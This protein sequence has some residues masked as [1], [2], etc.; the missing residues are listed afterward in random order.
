MNSAA[1]ACPQCQSS[2]PS[3]LCNTGAPVQCP[4]CDTT[5]QVEIFPAHFARMRTGPAAEG[6][7]EPGVS[8]CFYH[9]QKK[10]VVPCHGCGRFLCALCDLSFNGQHLCP[11]CLQ[12]GR[13]KGSIASLEDQRILYDGGALALS[14][15]P[16][17][18]GPFSLATAPV[19][20][21]FAVLSFFRPGSLVRRGRLRACLAILFAV[22]QIVGWS[23]LLYFAI[24]NF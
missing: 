20:I 4:A 8:S 19:A 13:K 2:L 21:Y 10:A 16:L 15:L 12:A 23:L 6:I 1:V 9:E 3:A 7:V 18:M 17:L 5:I 14:L 24:K 22:L 11:A